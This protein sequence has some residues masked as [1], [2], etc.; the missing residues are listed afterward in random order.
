MNCPN[1]GSEVPPGKK[2]CI[3]CGAPVGE[4]TG[5]MQQPP[6]QPTA[7]AAAPPSGAPAPGPG[8]KKTALVTAIVV[9]ALLVIGGAAAGIIIWRVAEG[10][11]LVAEITSVDLKRTD[12]KTVN[13]KDV[14]LD[15]NLQIEVTYRARF[16]QGDKGKLNITLVDGNSE[17]VRG[18]TYTVKSSGS[19]QTRA[20]EFLMSYS[21]GETF[22]ATAE[23]KV[24]RGKETRKDSESLEYYVAAGKGEEMQF[25]EAKAAATGKLEEATNAVKEISGMGINASDL[26]QLLTGSIAKLQAA[27]TVDEVNP[28]IADA[29]AVIKECANRKAQFQ[30]QQQQNQARD[31][32]R[33]NQAA[34]RERLWAYYD[35]GGNFPDSMSYLGNLPKCPSG[36]TYSYQ[37]DLSTDPPGLTVYCSVHGAL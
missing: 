30:A 6:V 35:E 32:C 5:V 31:T 12:E 18:N 36:G 4:P 20:D 2:F 9:I 11:K 21:E 1:C 14:P 17:E 3:N 37:A 26:A 24:T 13:L 34:L 23:L 8:K 29:D 19:Q 15:T 10:N 27:T 16:K 22:K 25:D 7:A 33:S 28:V